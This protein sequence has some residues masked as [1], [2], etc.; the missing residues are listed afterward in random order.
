[1]EQVKWLSVKQAQ[2]QPLR[3]ASIHAQR[4]SLIVRRHLVERRIVD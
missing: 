4:G 1:M 2:A 3:N